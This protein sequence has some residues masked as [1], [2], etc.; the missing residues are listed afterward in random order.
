MLGKERDSRKCSAMAFEL[1]MK[2]GKGQRTIESQT[3][4][5]SQSQPE[6][7]WPTNKVD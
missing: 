7:D 4:Q 3:Q 2:G 1:M 6:R 5:K